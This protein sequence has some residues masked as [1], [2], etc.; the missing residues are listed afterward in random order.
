MQ[1]TAPVFTGAMAGRVSEDAEV[2]T[3][4]LIVQARDGD[5]GRPRDILLSLLTNPGDVFQLDPKSGRLSTT[6][7]LDREVLGSLLS[8]QVE[9]EEIPVP[10]ER[11]GHSADVLKTKQNITVLI[12]D[13]NDSE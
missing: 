7:P 11:R 4:V 6:R 5:L 2:G 3:L 12:D 1:N 10:G 13:V 8:L 9:A